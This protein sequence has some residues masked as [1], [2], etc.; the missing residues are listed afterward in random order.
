M[1][2]REG[3]IRQE[4]VRRP[5]IQ[6]QTAVFTRGIEKRQE[7]LNNLLMDILQ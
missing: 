5:A 2:F 4:S 7:L 6:F 1:L 3:T